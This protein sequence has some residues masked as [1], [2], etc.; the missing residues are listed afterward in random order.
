[1]PPHWPQE[2]TCPRTAGTRETAAMRAALLNMLTEGRK[3]GEGEAGSGRLLG[4]HQPLC[5]QAL[6]STQIERNHAPSPS[7]EESKGLSVFDPCRAP[8]DGQSSVAPRAMVTEHGHCRRAVRRRSAGWWDSSERKLS[9]PPMA[10]PAMRQ[11][12]GEQVNALAN[13]HSKNN[14]I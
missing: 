14:Q 11:R 3:K 9:L 12:L 8:S 4:C 13:V 5:H 2:E 7:T 6:Y 10:I 1:M